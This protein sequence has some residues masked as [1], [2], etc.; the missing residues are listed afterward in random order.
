MDI[1]LHLLGSVSSF[2]LRLL[3]F[4][5]LFLGP[6]WLVLKLLTLG[7]GRAV[8][9]SSVASLWASGLQRPAPG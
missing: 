5:L 3:A 8:G 2:L 7:Q 1:V 4:P 9:Y 6:G